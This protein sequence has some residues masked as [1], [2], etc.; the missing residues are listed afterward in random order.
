[1]QH[2]RRVLCCLFVALI[3]IPLLA[4]QVGSIAGK[5]MASDKSA[6]PGVTVEA[7]SNVLPQPR[8]TSTDANGSY[9][10]QALIPGTYTV[11]FTLSGMNT[12]TRQAEVILRTVTPVDVTMGVAGVSE[13]ITVTAENTIVSKESTAIQSGLTSNEIQS[14]PIAQEYRDLQK[15]IP[16]VMYTQDQVRG[17][18]AGGAG[19]DNVYLFDGANVT[20]P[21]FGNLSSEPATHDIAQINIIRGGAKA[22]EFDRSGGFLIDSISKSGTN[23]LNGEVQYQI[24]RHNFSATPSIIT[25]LKYQ[26]DRDWWTA[27][28][29]GPIVHDRLFVF[30]S[31]YRPTYSRNNASNV[32]GDLPEY[33]K[34]RN[35]GFGKLTWTPTQ[36][37]LFNGSYRNSTSHSAN[38]AFTS[39]QAGTTGTTDVGGLKILVGEGSWVINPKSYASFKYNDFTNRTGSVPTTIVGSTFSTAPGTKLD[40]NNLPSLGA[41]L[42]PCPGPS[43]TTGCAINLAPNTAVNQFLAPYVNQ[44]GYSGTNGPTGGGTLGAASQFDRDDFF[45]K[46]GQAQYNLTLGSSVTHDLHVGAQGYTDSEDLDRT[47]NGWGTLSVIGGSTTCAVSVCGSAKPIFFQATVQQQSAG[48]ATIH[49]EFVSRNVE[50]NDSI[51]WGNWTYNV[52]VMASHDVLY[53]Q[54]L[55]KADNIAGFVKSPGTKY[56]MYS[57]PWNKEIQ[58]RLGTTWAYNGQDTVY[59][60]WAMYNPAATSLP[61]AA[62]WD[63]NL[64]N[65][66]NLDF[67]QTGTLIG[68]DPVKSSSGKLFVPDMKPRTVNEYLIGTAQQINR[69]L[70]ARVY[71]RYR[72]TTHFWEDTPNTARIDCGATAANLAKDPSK[73]NPPSNVPR[74]PYIANLNDQLAAIGSGSTY[75][76]ADLDG[77]FT[78]YYEATVESEWRHGSNWARGS[79]TWSHY[80]GNFDQDNTTGAGSGAG[81]GNDQNSFIGSSN[82]GDGPGRQIWDNKYGNLHGDRRNM[83][84]VYGGHDLPWHGSVGAFFVFQSGQPWEAW[85]RH[86]YDPL[87]GTSTS[88]TIRFAEHAGSRRTPSHHQLDLNYTQSFP[89]TAGFTMQLRGDIFNVYNRR[90]GYNPQPSVNTST[91]GQYLNSFDPRRFQ[92]AVNFMF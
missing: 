63:R 70:S 80:Y 22:T 86:V 38:N 6:L 35:E 15:L 78:K 41:F 55:A 18:S 58:P 27:D 9:A 64:R 24:I 50:L 20:L 57:V 85:D 87:I 40:I 7:R 10:L 71:T 45:R 62:S 51:R 13:S 39:T 81:A 44:Y 4:Q 43:A 12:V 66:I 84:K 34:T 8:V 72:K 61:R 75:V 65:T 88:D 49:S 74:E 52:G 1:M 73:C 16:G 69:D 91:F 77:A 32:Y 42:V 54:G 76:I 36:A 59:A 33:R 67:D 31:Y 47:T 83:F 3:S 56:K 37:L 28:L 68:V 17:P 11:T 25:S 29:G 30:G 79:Y 21:L 92:L 90:T 89:L 23:K 48:V 82:M 46:Q 5:V 14:L 2:F 60:S 26:E 19:S 53:G